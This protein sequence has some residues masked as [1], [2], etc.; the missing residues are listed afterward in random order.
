MFQS[1]LFENLTIFETNTPHALVAPFLA[2][3]PAIT[4]LVLDVC[5]PA[6]ATTA[7]ACPLTDCHLPHIEELSCPKGCVRPLLSA[8]TTASPLTNLQ[9]IQHTAHDSTFPLRKLFDFR[10]IPT[11][12]YLCHLRL[13]FDHTV[14]K[15]LHAISTAAPKLVTLKLV[16][17]T[18][19]DSV[20]YSFYDA[21]N[22]L[23]RFYG[24][25][26]TPLW[27][28]AY[29]WEGN[30]LLFTHLKRLLIRTSR[31][32]LPE[33]IPSSESEDELG[34]PECPREAFHPEGEDL[35]L[36]LKLAHRHQRENDVVRRWLISP[37]PF[38]TDF[39]IWTKAFAGRT[40]GE[41]MTVRMLDKRRGYNQ[42]K[43]IYDHPIRGREVCDGMFI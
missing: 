38:L 10:T 25:E 8:V 1:L 13:D 11:S 12:L 30:F 16:E 27:E 33:E 18:F 15:L 20:R 5:N 41:R 34:C 36:E 19:S 40:N 32:I 39:L 14:P 29:T 42:W 26:M 2:R 7:V 43:V 23:I 35:K 22:I 37:P 24:Q 21:H 28:D 17:S 3:H 6:T 4:N 9:V 31:S